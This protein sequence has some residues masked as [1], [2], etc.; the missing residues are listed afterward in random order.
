[1]DRCGAV[2]SVDVWVGLGLLRKLPLREIRQNVAAAMA[3]S[4]GHMGGQRGMPTEAD[5]LAVRAQAGRM[6]PFR[7]RKSGKFGIGRL[8]RGLLLRQ[9]V[10]CA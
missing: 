2:E 4:L 8:N 6:R 10:K 1:V 9:T 5:I 3:Y 7:L